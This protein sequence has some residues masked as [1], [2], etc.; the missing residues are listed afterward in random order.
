MPTN[1]H[2]HFYPKNRYLT[3]TEIKFRNLHITVMEV[4]VHNELHATTMPPRKPTHLEMLRDME[5][6]DRGECL[7]ACTMCRSNRHSR[8]MW[9]NDCFC[10]CGGGNG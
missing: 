1:R 9:R 8:C 3:V 10:Y 2:H 6:H 5:A 4:S 7:M